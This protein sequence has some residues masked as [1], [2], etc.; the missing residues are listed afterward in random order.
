MEAKEVQLTLK[1]FLKKLENLLD[2]GFT[3]AAADDAKTLTCGI[4]VKELNVRFWFPF[5]QLK[6]YCHKK[7]HL[8]TTGFHNKT[9]IHYIELINSIIDKYVPIVD[10]EGQRTWVRKDKTK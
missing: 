7:E 6:I 5:S 3:I 8:P 1:A 9:M 2:E 10:Q 4:K